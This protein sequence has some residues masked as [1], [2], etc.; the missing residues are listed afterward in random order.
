MCEAW[1]I[2]HIRLQDASCSTVVLCN[3]YQSFLVKGD[4]LCFVQR[5]FLTHKLNESSRDQV[6][7]QICHFQGH[8]EELLRDI[9]GKKKPVI[10]KTHHSIDKLADWECI[11]ARFCIEISKRYR[12]RYYNHI[13]TGYFYLHINIPVFCNYPFPYCVWLS[14]RV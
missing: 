12:Q 10:D 3:F 8:S 14:C 9:N 5:K 6:L 7:R 1:R 13:I 4:I 2:I 11:I